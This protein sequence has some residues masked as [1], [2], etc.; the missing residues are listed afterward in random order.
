MQISLETE[1][2][3]LLVTDM[4]SGEPINPIRSDNNED[5][6]K[7]LDALAVLGMGLLQSVLMLGTLLVTYKIPGHEKVR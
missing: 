3:L 1:R 5:S 6:L 2:I 7:E 4:E